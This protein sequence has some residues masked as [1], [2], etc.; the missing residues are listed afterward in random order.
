MT[1]SYIFLT[2]LTVEKR[3]IQIS[4]HYL[5]FSFRK[6]PEIVLFVKGKSICITL[7]IF[8]YK[9]MN[10]KFVVLLGHRNNKNDNTWGRSQ[11]EQ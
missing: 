10:N 6:I 9:N 8:V 5:N 1:M 2:A 11:K 7:Y 4:N 3:L